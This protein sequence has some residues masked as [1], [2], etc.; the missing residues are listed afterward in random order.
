MKWPWAVM[1]AAIA[2]AGCRSSQPA[3]NPFLRTTVPPPATGQ[4]MMV[5][6]GEPAPPVV[7]G[8]PGAAPAGT[9]PVVPAQPAPVVAPPVPQQPEEFHPP[10][11]SYLFHQSSHDRGG[12]PVG[13]E[14]QQAVAT[15]PPTDLGSSAADGAVRRATLQVP[16]ATSTTPSESTIVLRGG[17]A[18]ATRGDP[19]ERV[20]TMNVGQGAPENGLR[21]VGESSSQPQVAAASPRTVSSGQSVFRL[22]AGQTQS[23]ESTTAAVGGSSAV[24]TSSVAIITPPDAARASTQPTAPAP[25]AN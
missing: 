20:A 18:A 14:L 15:S 19:P 6:P 11:G 13:G 2:F 23:A 3:T 10:G 25:S 21:I 1:L 7:T 17:T 9:V 12:S 24:Q 5:M 22:R 16:V 4:P 8:V